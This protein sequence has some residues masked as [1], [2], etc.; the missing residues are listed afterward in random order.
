MSR[1]YKHTPYCGLKKDKFYKKYAN[2]KLRRKKLDH[3]Y[4]HG[5]Y[6]KDT[7]SWDICDWYEI[8]TKNFEEYYK[9]CVQFWYENH[10]RWYMLNEPFPTKE[11]CWKQYQEWYIRK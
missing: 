8:V 1:S 9:S 7:C 4:Q 3:D 2:R 11:Q 10:T 5:A 6:K